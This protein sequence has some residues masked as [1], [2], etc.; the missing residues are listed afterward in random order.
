VCDAASDAGSIFSLTMQ[1]NS[2]WKLEENPGMI[3]CMAVNPIESILVTCSRSGIRL[4]SLSSYPL[5]HVSSY[6][7]HSAPPFAAG[8]LRS[9]TSVATCDGNIHVWDVESRQTLSYLS[10]ASSAGYSSADKQGFSSMSVI[11][12]R[13]GVMPAMGA[14]G[15]DQLLTTL[16]A[17]LSYYDLR[18]GSAGRGLQSVADWLIPQLPPQQGNFISSSTADPLQ[19]TCA[20]SHENYVYAGSS[21]GGMWVIDRRMGQVLASWQAH[22]GPIIKVRVFYTEAAVYNNIYFSYVL[23]HM[24]AVVVVAAV[25]VV[26]VFSF[27]FFNFFCVHVFP[28]VAFRFMVYVFLLARS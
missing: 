23:F 12:P 26:R 8:F 7:H 21:L 3:R 28:H 22:D 11:Q 25:F 17:T 14:Y 16:N 15:D 4:W 6:S 24:V 18:A 2:Q 10:A 19:L 9:G 5:L 13:D 27:V 20:A 1:C